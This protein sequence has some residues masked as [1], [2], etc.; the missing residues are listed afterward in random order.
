MMTESVSD[1]TT[2][3]EVSAAEQTRKQREQR[4]DQIHTIEFGD[5]VEVECDSCG[6]STTVGIYGDQ[7]VSFGGCWGAGCDAF[8]KFQRRASE[9]SD[10]DE[11][12]QTQLVTDGG[13]D[14]PTGEN[15]QIHIVAGNSYNGGDARVLDTF[16][17]KT[18]AEQV[19]E[20]VNQMH[21]APLTR[22]TVYSREV[23]NV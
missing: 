12:Q 10:S 8:H 5:R 7:R 6:A 22:A 13:V 23:R 16:S 21:F 14:R 15:E 1:P 4:V 11:T 9:V 3:G 20:R 2:I 19:A 18:R 17:D